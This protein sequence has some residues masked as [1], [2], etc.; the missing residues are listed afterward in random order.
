L[1]K[2]ATIYVL[3]INNGKEIAFGQ[4]Y[5]FLWYKVGEN[6]SPDQE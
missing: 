3:F 5:Y 6:R 1:L 4:K 2:H